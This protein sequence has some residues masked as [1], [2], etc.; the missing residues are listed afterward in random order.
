MRVEDVINIVRL[1]MESIKGEKAFSLMTHKGLDSSGVKD[2]DKRDNK[3]ALEFNQ[4][5]VN[6]SREGMVSE[7]FESIRDATSYETARA[8]QDSESSV[9]MEQKKMIR[10]LVA[11]G[12]SKNEIV[13]EIQRVF[14]NDV[15]ILPQRLKNEGN[16]LGSVVIPGLL[17]TFTLGM[18]AYRRKRLQRISYANTQWKN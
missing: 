14:G 11:K 13:Y 6:Q 5:I 10:T 9:A 3:A 7:L 17:M 8:I 15:L 16:L 18:L 4:K 12:W 2:L 1:E